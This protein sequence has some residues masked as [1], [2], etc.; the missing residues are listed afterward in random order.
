M[1][2]LSQP[3]SAVQKADNDVTTNNDQNSNTVNVVKHVDP[4]SNLQQNADNSTANVATDSN[5]NTENP[6]KDGANKSQENSI[7]D[8]ERQTT[9]IF[10]VKKV[11]KAITANMLEENKVANVQDG[12]TNKGVDLVKFASNGG[13]DPAIWGTMDISKWQLDSRGNITGYTGDMTHII[14]PNSDDFAKAGKNYRQVSIN[15]REMAN[16]GSSSNPKVNTLAISLTNDK[17]V[18]ASNADWSYTFGF[19]SAL[20]QAN[21]EG[22]DT[23][24][25]QCH[26]LAQ[27][28]LSKIT[29]MH[30]LC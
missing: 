1:Q 26:M 28:R 22:L 24:Q 13:F 2:P 21:L 8:R 25:R 11:N 7:I 16:L 12:G 3:D 18:K 23:G 5:K 6:A 20:K 29:R 4:N 15:S 10:A 30:R 17:K 9:A 14:I 27:Q 19:T